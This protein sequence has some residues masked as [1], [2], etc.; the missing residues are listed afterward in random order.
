LPFR[1]AGVDVLPTVFVPRT[2]SQRPPDTE[3][4][5][6]RGGLARQQQAGK[7]SCTDPGA[8]G[9]ESLH[10]RTAGV[11]SRVGFRAQ[12]RA[13]GRGRRLASAVPRQARRRSRISAPWSTTI[14]LSVP[15]CHCLT[16]ISGDQAESRARSRTTALGTP[17]LRARYRPRL[18]PLTTRAMFEGLPPRPPP[19]QEAHQLIRA[20]GS[21][22]FGVVVTA[23][24]PQSLLL[25]GGY[26]LVRDPAV[27]ARE[28]PG[29][30]VRRAA[31]PDAARSATPRGR[32]RARGRRGR[33]AQRRR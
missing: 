8:S 5:L 20:H 9:A 21:R 12:D 14:A 27:C 30:P 7:R 3:Q 18:S 28:Q 11:A 13:N 31:G 4:G 6:A 26:P 29:D 16:A 15:L 33:A 19:K 24:S 1:A 32:R 2:S 23:C 22:L 25:C 17:S 10:Q